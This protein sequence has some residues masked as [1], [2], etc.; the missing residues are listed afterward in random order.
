MVI[1]ESSPKYLFSDDQK[2]GDDSLKKLAARLEP[3]AAEIKTLE[4]A[5]TGTLSGFAPL[6]AFAKEH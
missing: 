5:H 6:Q 2:Q 4:F 1:P 3:R